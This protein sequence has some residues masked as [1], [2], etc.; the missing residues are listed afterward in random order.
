MP[1]IWRF[2]LQLSEV[3]MSIMFGYRLFHVPNT[4]RPAICGQVGDMENKHKMK[5]SSPIVDV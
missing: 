2:K 1:K 3:P 4:E 5:S